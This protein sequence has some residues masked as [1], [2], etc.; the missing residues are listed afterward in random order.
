MSEEYTG[1]SVSYYRIEIINPTTS[2]KPYVAE[3]NDIIEALDMNYAEGNA[4]KA[5]WRACAARKGKT[6]KGYDSPRYDWEKV[7]FFAER[8]LSNINEDTRNNERH[9]RGIIPPPVRT[10]A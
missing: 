2:D 4:F 1:G 8:M 6:K 7:K 5:I 3:C 9:E 10:S